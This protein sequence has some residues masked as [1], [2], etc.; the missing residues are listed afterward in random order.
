MSNI[1]SMLMIACFYFGCAHAQPEQ[2]SEKILIVYLSRTGNTKAIAEMIHKNMGGDIVLIELEQPYPADY[3]VT[4]EQVA[5]ENEKGYLPPLK[6]GL[7]SIGK[8]DVVFV[9]FPTWGMKLPPP[10]KS[11]LTQYDLSGK[12]V[13]PFNTNA[14]YG[15][16]SSFETLKD[17][18][19]DSK[20]LAGFSMKGGVEKDGVLFIMEGNKAREAVADVEAWLKK[21]NM[22]K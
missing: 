12:T 9:G 20:V 18:C 22:L 7:D 16:G 17:M 11:F 10:V 14:G 6:M 19:Q 15:V 4:V 2:A 21:I 1:I 13:V 8:Y 3:K 5:E